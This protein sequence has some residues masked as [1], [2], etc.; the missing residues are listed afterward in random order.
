MG[1]NHSICRSLCKSQLIST[2]ASTYYLK[3]TLVKQ[4]SHRSLNK[5]RM[6]IELTSRLVLNKVADSLSHNHNQ[7]SVHEDDE[8]F[9]YAKLHNNSNPIKKKY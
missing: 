2:T 4:L 3:S 5:H 8:K 9:S 1:G 7:P 6:V